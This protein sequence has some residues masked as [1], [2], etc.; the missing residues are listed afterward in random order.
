M[1]S[2]GMVGYRLG[3]PLPY[4]RIDSGWGRVKARPY[5]SPVLADAAPSFPQIMAVAIRRHFPEG[6]PR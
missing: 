4:A 2:F 5:I 6:G 1:K 3:S